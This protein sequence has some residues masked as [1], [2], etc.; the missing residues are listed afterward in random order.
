MSGHSKLLVITLFL[1]LLLGTGAA[2]A[3]IST[4][5]ANLVEVGS[6]ELRWLGMEVY[7]ARLL[8]GGERFSGDF[9]AGPVALEI[10][11]RR[12]IPSERLVRTT[13]REWQRLRQELQ[14]PEAPRVRQWLGE[15]AAIWPDVTPGDRLIALVDPAGETRFYG[16]DGLLGVVSDPEFGPAF[17]G[18]WLHPATRAAELRA[19]LLGSPQ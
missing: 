11:Y 19:E 14:L 4:V 3:S 7:E 8:S 12:N 15:I 6:G 1:A 17:L 16:N 18:I 13:E 5:P 10:T 2:G 9:A